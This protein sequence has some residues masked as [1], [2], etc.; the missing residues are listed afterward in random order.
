VAAMAAVLTE[1]MAAAT[2][3]VLMVVVAATATASKM[4]TRYQRRC[5]TL[6]PVLL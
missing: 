6:I 4:S 1:A 5:F 2:A 3:A